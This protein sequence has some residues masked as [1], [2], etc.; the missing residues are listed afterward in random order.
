MDLELNTAGVALLT[1]R[2]ISE[3][4][5]LQA[6]LSDNST[7]ALQTGTGASDSPLT[8]VQLVVSVAVEM[9]ARV[10]DP[11]EVGKATETL[12]MQE[13][14]VTVESVEETRHD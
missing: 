5:P 4:Y 1:P 3:T 14:P 6:I 10:L 12:G 11:A 8:E 9:A 13:G 7:V 2:T